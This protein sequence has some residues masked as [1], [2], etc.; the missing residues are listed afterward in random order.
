MK[1]RFTAQCP[2]ARVVCAAGLLASA[3][4]QPAPGQAAKPD[5][6]AVPSAQERLLSREDFERSSVDRAYKLKFTESAQDANEIL[7]AMRN[8]LDPQ[9]KIFL[10]PSTRTIV[11]RAPEAQQARFVQLLATLD[12][13]HPHYRLTYTLTEMEGGRK[14]GV[15]HFTMSVLPGQHTQLKQGS[16]L[17]IM[18]GADAG[19]QITYLDVGVNIDATIEESQGGGTLKSRIEDSSV[20]PDSSTAANPHPVLRQTFLEG[21]TTLTVGKV[22]SI[23]SLD[24]PSS[25]HHFDIDVVLEPSN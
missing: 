10:L 21:S 22:Q 5:L 2:A 3:L 8:I 4:A 15:Q 16:R 7:T 14:L 24:V 17:P 11:V 13:Q 6:S 12:Q 19:Q 9:V 25:T 1:L 20:A 23:G 18:T